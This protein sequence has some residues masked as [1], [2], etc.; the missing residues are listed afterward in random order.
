MA[1]F[2][3]MAVLILAVVGLSIDAG[4]SYLSSDK[5]ER[6]AAAAALAGVAYLPT[7]WT[8]AQAVAY[9]EA[10]RNG[11]T[12]GVNSVT[13]TPS[14]PAGT[15]NEMTVTISV[16]VPTTFLQLIGFGPH[17]VTR[18]A[19]AEY[20]PPIALGQ[21]GGQLGT[22]LGSG[23]ACDGIPTS[24]QAGGY[25][26]PGSGCSGLGSG[27]D[28]FYIL[29]TEAWGVQR[30]QGDGFTP[31]P[32]EPATICPNPQ[33]SGTGSCVASPPDYHT[34]SAMR[35]TDISGSSLNLNAAGGQNYLITIPAG[36]T[37]DVQIYNPS[38]APNDDDGNLNSVYTL[39]E[40]DSDFPQTCDS[41]ACA[42]PDSTQSDYATLAYTLFQV[43]TLAARLSDVEVSQ[44]L[45][46][47]LNAAHLE[48][49][50]AGGTVPNL[51]SASFFYWPNGTGAK[52]TV[53]G[54]VPAMFHNWVSIV[55]PTL[56][57]NSSTDSDYSNDHQ[58]Y[59]T[60]TQFNVNG[61]GTCSGSLDCYIHNT[62]AQTEYYRL[63]ID[64]LYANGTTVTASNTTSA[65][66]QDESS[67]Q[68]LAHKAYAIQVVPPAV[69]GASCNG[70]SVAAMDDLT[71][72][73]PVM[74]SQCQNFEIPLFYLDPSYAGQTIT[75]QL[76][77]LG[78]VGGGAAYVGVLEPT[79][80]SGTAPTCTTIPSGFA[81]LASG[82]S[83]D[84]IGTSLYDPG[85]SYL[86]EA[87]ASGS[88]VDPGGSSSDAVIQTANS[89][90]GGSI[91]NGQWL[92]LQIQVPQSYNLPSS[93]TT[94]IVTPANALQ[95]AQ[96]CYWNLYYS[97]ASNAT[98]GDTFS[99]TAGFG[100]SPDRLLP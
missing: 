58:L 26:G 45:F 1:I 8:D 81:Q 60:A 69:A 48:L 83:I 54:A 62:T 35:G 96:Q 4:I 98:A 97:V 43:P 61:M 80:V 64:T 79:D 12:D 100:G 74:G 59:R 15:T 9:S 33:G 77:D 2:A 90:G 46:Y 93:C 19:T 7:D 36:Q 44:Q 5:V 55:Q 84:D 32:N 52:T 78:D 38:F 10:T 51:A 23:H 75:V 31:T 66:A 17:N 91:W 73:T 50:S 68:P 63:R 72:Y 22:T 20:L 85:S 88:A 70:C 34:I 87:N 39:H 40:E 37:A 42:S 86:A 25:G 89:S 11:F 30:S 21:P 28:N 56:Q 27:G 41:G 65:N 13:V 71:V 57:I 49:T 6:A 29:R 94:T 3:L 53:T 24:T 92:Q 67:G 76:F 99:F 95:I 82:T 16:S 18:S 14:R 47:P